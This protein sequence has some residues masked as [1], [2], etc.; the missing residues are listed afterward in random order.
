VE[1]LAPIQAGDVLE[2]TATITRIGNRSRELRFEARVVCR[3][4]PDHGPSAARVLAPPVVVTRATGTVVVP[5][6]NS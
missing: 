2:A 6:G 3:A 4:T 1:F 5:G